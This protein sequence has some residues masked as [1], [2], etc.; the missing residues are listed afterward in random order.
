MLALNH[1]DFPHDAS[2]RA[3]GA[4]LVKLQEKLIRVTAIDGAMGM[5][6]DDGCWRVQTKHTSENQQIS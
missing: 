3:F 2:F 5:T 6:W 1:G 4:W